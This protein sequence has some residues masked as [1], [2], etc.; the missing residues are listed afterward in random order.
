MSEA[1]NGAVQPIPRNLP[2]LY[3]VL[4]GV[5]MNYALRVAEFEQLLLSALLARP[6]G[7]ARPAGAGQRAAG[8]RRRAS[9]AAAAARRP[10][11]AGGA[12]RAARAGG[13]ARASAAAAAGRAPV[14][15]LVGAPNSYAPRS[16]AAPT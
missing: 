10:R 2:G 9:D 7:R 12:A 11:R 6:A 4:G 8:A 5:K 16:G 13:A 14:P 3:S 15:G 1:F